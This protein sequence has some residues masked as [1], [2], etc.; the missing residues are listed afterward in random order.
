VKL[1]LLDKSAEAEK[2]TAESSE[3]AEKEETEVRK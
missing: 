3:K 1:P 2:K